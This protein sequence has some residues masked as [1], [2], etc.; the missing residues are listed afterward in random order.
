[1]RTA[2]IR[3]IYEESSP[4]HAS[5]SLQRWRGKKCCP[6]AHSPNSLQEMWSMLSAQLFCCRNGAPSSS[7]GSL[8]LQTPGAPPKGLHGAGAIAHGDPGS[9]EGAGR[10]S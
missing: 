3:R 4:G 6:G 2:R 10:G 9:G 7:R 8:W 1:M 5:A